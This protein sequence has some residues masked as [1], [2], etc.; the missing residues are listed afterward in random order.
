MT[1]LQESLEGLGFGALRSGTNFQDISYRGSFLMILTVLA[2]FP[3][4]C[5]Y[6]F[7]VLADIDFWYKVGC[8]I[9]HLVIS[10]SGLSM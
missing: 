8:P 3:S 6:F 9:G 7:F 1:I 2:L 5:G 10:T 4:Y